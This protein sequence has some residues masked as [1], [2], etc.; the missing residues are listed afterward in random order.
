MRPTPS[1]VAKTVS[2]VLNATWPITLDESLQWLQAMGI[3]TDGARETPRDGAS[4]SWQLA[5]VL[6]WGTTSAGWGTYRDEFCDVFWFLWEG[7]SSED[8][9]QAAHVLAESITGARGAAK[10]ASV[11]S[12]LSGASRWWQLD[13]HTIEM[14]AYHGLPNPN[15]CPTGHPCVQ[16]H[17]SLRARA[18]PQEVEAQ[19]TQASPGV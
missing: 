5:P 2:H 12:P 7:G 17:I 14:Y 19:R 13:Q 15:G 4:R 16:L 1:E 11:A 8:V 3:Q 6:A 9:T 10:E 18:E